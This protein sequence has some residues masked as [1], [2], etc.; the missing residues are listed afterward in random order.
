MRRA[1]RSTTPLKLNF[2]CSAKRTAEIFCGASCCRSKFTTVRG[3]NQGKVFLSLCSLST[4]SGEGWGEASNRKM[5]RVVG[6][7]RRREDANRSRLFQF[8]FLNYKHLR[9]TS[10][11]ILDTRVQY[12]KLDIARGFRFHLLARNWKFRQRI[13]ASGVQIL[14]ANRRSVEDL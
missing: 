4:L 14:E 13:W 12:V 1:F 7:Q 6:E 2:A 10:P 3:E 11:F 9:K 5:K 8:F